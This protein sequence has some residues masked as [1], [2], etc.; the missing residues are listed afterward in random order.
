MQEE[1]EDGR[2]VRRAPELVEA[3]EQFVHVLGVECFVVRCE[4]F[5]EAQRLTPSIPPL[6]FSVGICVRI[7]HFSDEVGEQGG[8]HVFP[9]FRPRRTGCFS[10]HF[11]DV[12]GDPL[13]PDQGIESGLCSSFVVCRLR[14]FHLL[15][16]FDSVWVGLGSQHGFGVDGECNDQQ[17]SADEQFAPC[18]FCP[19]HATD[20]VGVGSGLISDLVPFPKGMDPGWVTPTRGWESSV[21]NGSPDP[22][23][24][25]SPTKGK[26][27]TGGVGWKGTIQPRP[28][29]D[30]KRV[31][32]TT[33]HHGMERQDPP[34]GRLRSW[35]L[36]TA[37]T[38]HPRRTGGSKRIPKEIP[39]HG[40]RW[41]PES[42]GDRRSKPRQSDRH[43]NRTDRKKIH[44]RMRMR[45]T[46]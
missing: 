18:G 26:T 27:G 19:F 23:P 24:S 36:G 40:T 41:K 16:S 4:H 39:G 46:R 22:C 7:L 3:L 34:T 2:D 1:R 21:N 30:R 11:G 43:R 20:V 45:R 44:T 35:V 31:G 29:D 13:P 42:R 10:Q 33:D 25:P 9:L 12:F 15:L 6:V 14:P 5:V 32:R 38:T 37:G 8:T 28:I 17:Q